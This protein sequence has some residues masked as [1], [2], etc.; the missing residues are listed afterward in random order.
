MTM[1]V[2]RADASAPVEAPLMKK[3]PKVH[4]FLY[5]SLAFGRTRVGLAIL[6][7]MVFI[8]IFGGL[9][10]PHS[11]YVFV[12]EPF[13][14]SAP[15]V[16]LGTDYLGR[17]LLSRFLNGGH[18]ILLL[19]VLGTFFGVGG[20]TAVGLIAGYRGGWADEALMRTMDLI[21]SFPSIVFALLLISVLGPH[22]WLLVVVVAVSFTPHTSRVVRSSTVQLVESD[23]VKYAEGT[24]MKMGK[25][26]AKEIMPNIAAVLT[27]EFGIRFTNSIGMIAGLDYLGL[28]V[29]PPTPD[30]GLMI[31]ENQIGLVVQPLTV[32]LPVFAIA[33]LAVGANLVTDGIGKAVAGSDR[34]VNNG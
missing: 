24:G 22:D 11:P 27:V 3:P 15:G 5:Q 2:T 17:D 16:P 7:V 23:F 25:L 14:A 6:A 18:I 4:G 21:L 34:K 31:Q 32:L 30:W 1:T 12:G 29:R 8:A 28:G 19:A 33:L 10:A 26:I 13:S 20:G 9:F